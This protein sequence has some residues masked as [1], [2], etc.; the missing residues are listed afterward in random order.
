MKLSDTCVCQV[1]RIKDNCAQQV[2]WIQT[3]YQGQVK[4]LRDI[5][6]YGT[7]HLS[8]LR[9]QYYDQVK[10]TTFSL[11]FWQT[12]YYYQTF[13]CYD[14]KSNTITTSNLYT[15]RYVSFIGHHAI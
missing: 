3:S 4:H 12:R 11:L 9:D 2:E 15:F 8:A 13:L 6:D 1:H 5:R 14:S 7:N 10:Y